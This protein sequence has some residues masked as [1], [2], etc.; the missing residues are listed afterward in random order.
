MAFDPNIHE[1]DPATGYHVFKGTGR[2]VGI[3]PAPIE[4][5]S[6]ETEY[7]K[8]VVPH[9]GHITYHPLYGHASTPLFS[10][11]SVNRVG[12]EVTVLVHDA[13]EEER[14]RS[15]PSQSSA[16]TQEA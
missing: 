5:V 9:P 16:P 13:E 3:D 2:R 1:V 14:A 15:D 6:D 11:C 7:P 10:E 4:R 8:W 12:G